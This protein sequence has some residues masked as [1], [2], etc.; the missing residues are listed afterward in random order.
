MTAAAGSSVPAG[1]VEVLLGTDAT[2][3]TRRHQLRRLVL[4]PGQLRGQFPVRQS[5]LTGGQ[6]PG[7]ARVRAPN[8]KYGIP[9]VY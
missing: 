5:H 4:F 7:G 6:R 1:H 2:V 9:C 3:G 8:A